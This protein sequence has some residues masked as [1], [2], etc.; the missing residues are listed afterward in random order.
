[1]ETMLDVIDLTVK[2]GQVTSV[3][4]VNIK[5][6]RGEAVTVLGSN[7]AGKS[8]IINTISGIRR[9]SRGEIRFIGVDITS[10][11]PELIV[12]LG[13]LQV[14][15]GKATLSRLRVSDNLKIGA[16]LRKDAV[17]IQKDLDMVYKRFPILAE[18][19]KQYAGN[20]SGGEQRMLAIGMALMAKPKLMM[21]DE[22][23]LGLAPLVVS[24][25]FKII[26]SLKG[27]GMTILLVEQNARLALLHS[28]RGYILETGSIVLSGKADWLL[29]NEQVREA[30]LGSGKDKASKATGK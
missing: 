14:P 3:S 2:Y 18:R 25:M 16:Y 6:E 4:H 10:L 12:G 17:G 1:M 28:E 27:E 13:L 30:Y 19:R 29:N 9:A 20:L 7:G 8:T 21:L 22:P 11:S 15:E 23:S 26:S 5:V 24:E